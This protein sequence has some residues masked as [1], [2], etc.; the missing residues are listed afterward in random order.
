MMDRRDL[1]TG[2]F[3]RASLDLSDPIQSSY[4]YAKLVGSAGNAMVH[5]SLEGTIFALLPDGVQPFIRFQALLKGVW[6]RKD[7]FQLEDLLYSHYMK[8]VF[9]IILIPVNQ[10]RFLR[11]LLPMK[12]TCLLASR[13]GLTIES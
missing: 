1:I 12:P 11:I 7:V 8:L 4:A 10:S 5:Y 13:E 9:F 6:K 3:S 2:Q